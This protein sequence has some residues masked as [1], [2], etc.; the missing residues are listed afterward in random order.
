[1]RSFRRPASC[2][3][4]NPAARV[5]PA[6]VWV[7]DSASPSVVKNTLARARS[8]DISTPVSVIMPTRGSLSSA[9]SSPDNSR[10]IWSATR[11]SLCG[12]GMRSSDAE[13]SE[14]PSCGRILRRARRSWRL[15]RTLQGP[16]NFLDFVDL[17]L[18]ADPEIVVALHRHA[19]FESGLHLA[20]VVLEALER[21]DLA[22]MHD[23]VVAQ[24]PHQ[25][26]TA[27]Q[28]LEHHATGHCAD[29]GDLEYL[30][31]V[32]EPEYVFLF[33]RRQHSRERRLHFVDGVVDD[34][35]V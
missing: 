30:A 16:R 35:V 20:H 14:P 11:L 9:R 26:V 34:V 1:M 32:D 31:H 27:H 8:G 3:R 22:R 6:S 17:E 21:I 7:R 13:R 25:R 18:V 33:F 28:A 4:R 29:L 2:A 10:W 23:H 24:H 19:A 5:S 15:A 12:F